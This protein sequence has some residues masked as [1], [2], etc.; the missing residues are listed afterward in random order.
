MS[1]DSDYRL[2]LGQRAVDLGRILALVGE[3]YELRPA[4]SPPTAAAEFVAPDLASIDQFLT[5][6]EQ[7]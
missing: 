4:D 2:A 7:S 6:L 1:E 5:R 3:Q